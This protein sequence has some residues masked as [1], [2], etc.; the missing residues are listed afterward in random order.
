MDA[1][2]AALGPLVDA[3]D[4][5]RPQLPP[6]PA[7]DASA[8]LLSGSAGAYSALP[9]WRVFRNAGVPLAR[10]VFALIAVANVAAIAY[11]VYAFA[12]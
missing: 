2:A 10:A 6:P 7:S 5:P 3:D 12:T 11:Q 9:R 4:R 8:P 1:E